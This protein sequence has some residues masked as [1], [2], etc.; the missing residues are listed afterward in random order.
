MAKSRPPQRPASDA[1]TSA[2][3]PVAALRGEPA[4][5]KRAQRWEAVKTYGSA[6]L[7]FLFLRTFLVEAFRIP[8][9]SMI[10]TL[11]VGDWLF[12]NKLRYGPVVPFTGIRLKGYA[13]PARED[14]VVFVSPYQPDE[15]AIG[16]DPTPVLVKRLMGLPGDTV[17]MRGGVFHVNGRPMPQTG[18][19]T[20][21]PTG[22]PDETN[23][24][25]AWQANYVVRGTRFGEPPATPTHDHWGPLVI[26]EGQF[27]MLG[28]NRYASKDSRYWGLVPRDNIRGRPLFVY[29]SYNADDSD[30]P[31]PW[32]L[33]IRWGRLLH[34]IR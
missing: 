1:P 9:G 22:D 17:M 27:F 4:A 28:D 5:A 24:L 20:R 15:A 12:V 13:E 10:P 30:R 16:K 2:P 14:V 21:N 25:F 3:N 23:P 31:A 18:E 6:L 7:L 19:A 26:P 29:Y 32:L 11:L 8:S 33:D 34:W